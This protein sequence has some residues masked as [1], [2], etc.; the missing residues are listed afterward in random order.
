MKWFKHDSDA[1]TDARIKKLILRYG[2]EGYAIYFHCLELIAGDISETNVTFELEHDAEI[3][4]DNLKIKGDSQKSGIDRVNEIMRY[5][6][7]LEL[8][9]HDNGHIRC[10]KM[11]KRI[12]SSMTSSVKLRQLIA[13]AKSHDDVMTQSCI[14]MEQH[15]RREEIRRDEKRI[16][17]N[18]NM[19]PV[20]RKR[21]TKPTVEEV[22]AYLVSSSITNVKPQ[23][24]WDYYESKGWKVGK[25]PMKD[26]RAAV[27]T[28]ANKATFSPQ[29]PLP[30]HKQETFLDMPDEKPF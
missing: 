23:I 15:A 18:N 9:T 21:F 30:I 17:D 10:Y 4:A 25:A 28:W 2:A 22:H 20:N 27:R 14:P 26:W 11:A 12:D 19:E 13:D 3:I 5:I 24:F 29:K 1:S 16:E 6:I 8:F 7:D